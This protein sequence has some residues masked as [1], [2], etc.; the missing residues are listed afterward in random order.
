M[1]FKIFNI[2]VPESEPE[3]E[4]MNRFLRGNRIVAVEKQLLSV[5]NTSYRSFC[6]QYIVA[7]TSDSKATFTQG[8][9][10]EKID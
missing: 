4:E 6:V 7:G 2:P 5:G 9:R 3:A 1:Q 10:K 8:E